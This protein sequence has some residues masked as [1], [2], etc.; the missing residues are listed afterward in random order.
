MNLQSNN[1]E[2]NNLYLS[3]KAILII[4]II[5]VNKNLN[6]RKNVIN[7]NRINKYYISNHKIN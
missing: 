6:I 5:L 1:E 7:I 4:L 3:I 2:N